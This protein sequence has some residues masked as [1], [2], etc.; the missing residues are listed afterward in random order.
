[1]ADARELTA[2][3]RDR[4]QPLIEETEIPIR[5]TA[6]EMTVSDEEI[7]PLAAKA[8][9]HW[10]FEREIV[11]SEL[12]FEEYSDEQLIGLLAHEIGHHDGRHILVKRV[13]KLCPCCRAH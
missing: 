1:M 6:T 12:C 10:P 5:V 9:G 11:L 3:E 2:E 13:C 4:L 8:V 7:I